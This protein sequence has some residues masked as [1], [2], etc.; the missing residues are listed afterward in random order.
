MV[1][2]GGVRGENGG[3][4]ESGGRCGGGEDVGHRSPKFLSSEKASEQKLPV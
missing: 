3:R 1:G 2:R 4:R